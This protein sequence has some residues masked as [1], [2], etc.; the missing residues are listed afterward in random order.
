MASPP[1][2]ELA[3]GDGV[4]LPSLVGK[5]VR[6]VTEI[7]QKLGVNPVLVGNGI[8]QQQQ[9]EAGA[10]TRHGGSVTVWFGRPPE[11]AQARN[12]KAAR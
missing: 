5:T 1:T 3:E 2:V 9:P 10:V 7:C 6:Q 11:V 4:E 8:A 12:Q